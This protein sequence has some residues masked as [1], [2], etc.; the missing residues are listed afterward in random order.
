M[1]RPVRL[2]MNKM[3]TA[4]L[5]SLFEFSKFLFDVNRKDI[6]LSH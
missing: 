5:C 1:K 4:E 3:A 2:H 6:I